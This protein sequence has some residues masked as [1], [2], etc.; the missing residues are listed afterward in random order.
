MSTCAIFLQLGPNPSFLNGDKLGRGQSG[1]L[2]HGGTL[3]L[4]NQRHPFTLDVSLSSAC[5][6]TQ[7]NLK[8]S[9]KTKGGRNR[10]EAESSPSPKRS[11]KDFFSVSPSKVKHHFFLV[12]LIDL[13][14]TTNKFIWLWKWLDVYFFV[15][16]SKRQLNTERDQPEVKRQKL[17][18]EERLSEE[19]LKE[20]QEFAEKNMTEEKKDTQS[21]PSSSPAKACMKSSWQQTG[22]LMFYTAAGVKV[23]NKVGNGSFLEQYTRFSGMFV[24]RTT[25]LGLYPCCL[26][27]D[28]WV[29]YWWMYYHHQIWKSLSHR[30]WWLEVCSFSSMCSLIIVSLLFPVCAVPLPLF[31]FQPCLPPTESSKA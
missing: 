17:D 28:C 10:M 5:S 26:L 7:R 14:C 11:I 25:K 6:M 8:V 27:S 18:E 23:S 13:W 21:S 29:W 9:D 12:R 16:A 31:W 2:T 20:L 19:K 22:T 30:T 15:Q 3:Y 4:V 1:K 24:L